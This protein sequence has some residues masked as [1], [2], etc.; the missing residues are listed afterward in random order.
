MGWDAD[1]QRKTELQFLLKT[2]NTMNG[3][4]NSNFIIL[5]VSLKQDISYIVEEV[6]KKLQ[7]LDNL[8]YLKFS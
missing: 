7:K 1:L 5:F 6:Q 8:S 4:G 3:K 2:W